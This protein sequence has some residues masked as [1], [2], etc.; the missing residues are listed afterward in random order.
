MGASMNKLFFLIA[1]LLIFASP[2]YAIFFL[3]GVGGKPSKKDR[4]DYALRASNYDGQVFHNEV[5]FKLMLSDATPDENTASQ[6]GTRPEKPL[7]L[8]TPSFVEAASKE[9]FTITWFGHSSLLIQMGGKNILLDPVLSRRLS[10]VTWIGPSRFTPSPIT[11]DE[12]PHIDLLILSHDHYD[13]L[14]YQVIK[15]ISSKVDKVIVPL[16]VECHLRK[17]K[18]DMSK[19]ENM[20]WWEEVQL[21]GLLLACTPAQ[22]FSG[23]WL[24]GRNRTLWASW[25]LKTADK[26]VFYNGDSGFGPHYAA[27]HEKYGDF[28]L[29][30]ME[31]GQYNT[32]WAK[33]HSFP[34]EGIDAMKILGTKLAMPIHWGAFVLST[35]AWDDPVERFTR[36]AESIALPYI[37]PQIGQTVNLKSDL[38]PHQ[39]KWWRDLQ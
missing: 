3:P 9:D 29:A 27:I 18:F 13:H 7:P 2:V 38:S 5:D 15:K 22:H 31:C 14:D 36:H 6:K 16:G 28:D 12:L 4:A 11:V 25:V 19:V 26:Q 37:T 20:A 34:E 24:S 17:W 30:L 21:D 8:A 32:R 33:V 39:E 23:R 1:G 35:H 10:P